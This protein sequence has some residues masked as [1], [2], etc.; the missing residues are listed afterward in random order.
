MADNTRRDA[1]SHFFNPIAEIYK[2]HDNLPHWHQGDV[3]IFVT[4]RLGDSL[5]KEKLDQWQQERG[6]WLAANP[7]PWDESTKADY[8]KHFSQQFDEWLDQGSGS[9]VLRDPAN[10]KIVANALRHFD[11]ER[12]ELASFVVMPNHVHALFRTNGKHV[13][14]EIL[15]SWKGF[16]AREINKRIGKNGTLWQEEYWDR[17]I[18]TEHHFI[19]AAKYIREN[20]IK[21]RLR[22]GEFVFWERQVSTHEEEA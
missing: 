8:H 18:R 7:Q 13:L 21:A 15:K 4:W 1:S 14:S 5:P 6:V 17:L 9:C 3:W 16:T 12:Y 20:P 19:K 10:S 2:Y 22:E 11:G